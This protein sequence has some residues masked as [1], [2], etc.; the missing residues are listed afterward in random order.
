MQTD[1]SDGASSE[2][3]PEQSLTEEEKKEKRLEEGIGL[4]HILIDCVTA[5]LDPQSV[6]EPAEQVMGNQKLPTSKE[7]GILE[8]VVKENVYNE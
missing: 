4:Q 3:S 5:L 1:V 2:L 7:V 6:P 8:I